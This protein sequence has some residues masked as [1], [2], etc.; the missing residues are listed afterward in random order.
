[1]A[2]GAQGPRH[3]RHGDEFVSETAEQGGLQVRGIR[4]SFGQ[5]EVLRDIDLDVADGE[6]VT[7]LGP[8]GCGKTTLLRVIAGFIEPSA[9]TVAI[10]GRTMNSVRPHRRPV[11]MVFQRPTLFP[12]LDVFENVAFGLRVDRLLKEEI[13]ERIG[14]ALDL[15]RMPGYEGRRAS[16]LSGGQLQRVALARALVKRP[17]VL[18]LDEP[19]S[20]LDLKIRLEMEVE[21]R[22]VHRET[23]ASW[24]YVTHDQREALALSDRIA[25]FEHGHIDQL[26]DPTTIY[27]RPASAYAAS[28]VGNANVLACEVE[29]HDAAC[30]ARIAGVVMPVGEAGLSGPAWLVLRPENVQ[31]QAAAEVEHGL[32]AVVQDVAFRGVAFSYQLAVAGLDDPVKAEVPAGAQHPL[33]IGSEVQVAWDGDAAIILPR[34]T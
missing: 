16:E 19:L 20:A 4:H 33:E 12:H 24:I 5:E 13:D 29:G 27:R 10:G 15:V 7:F 8:S 9:G 17:R 32:S 2:R 30:V 6:F 26:A 31:V 23:G 1:M 25:V 14:W 11:N 21:L 28:F 18:L 34:E 22:R 3:R